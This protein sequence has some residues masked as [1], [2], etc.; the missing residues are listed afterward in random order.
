MMIDPDLLKT[1]GAR[2]FPGQRPAT[3]SMS[4]VARR[5]KQ[6]HVTDACFL[7]METITFRNEQPRKAIRAAPTCIASLAHGAKIQPKDTYPAPSPD[8]EAGCY[9]RKI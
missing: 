4:N 3:C 6:K 7:V 9:P 2:A 5:F 1:A 8:D